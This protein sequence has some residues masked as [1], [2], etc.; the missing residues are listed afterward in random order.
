M[1]EISDVATDPS[2]QWTQISGRAGAEFTNAG[3]PVRFAVTGVR[4]G[5]NIKVILEP[6]GEGIVSGYPV[7]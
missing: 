7:P 6:G 2:L 4:D 5:V 1:N 3:R